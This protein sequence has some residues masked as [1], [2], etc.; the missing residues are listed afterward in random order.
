[1]NAI[2]YLK[3]R[4]WLLPR[5]P[6]RKREMR[7]RWAVLGRLDKGITAITILI[8]GFRWTVFGQCI[9]NLLSKY[10]SI[11]DVRCLSAPF[12]YEASDHVATPYG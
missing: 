11:L 5:L 2:W 6:N 8:P 12:S 7:T 10:M 3:K 9:Y 1:M 4:A